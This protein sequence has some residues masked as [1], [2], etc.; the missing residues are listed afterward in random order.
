MRIGD[1]VSK[2]RLIAKI[3]Y[4]SDSEFGLELGD[5]LYKHY[6]TIK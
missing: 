4:Q 3:H 1:E 6:E 5:A 2:S